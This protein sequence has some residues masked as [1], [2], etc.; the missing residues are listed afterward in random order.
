M[1]FKQTQLKSDTLPLHIREMLGEQPE[2][3]VDSL[4]IGE[5]LSDTQKKAFEKFK[6]GEDKR[7]KRCPFFMKCKI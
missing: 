6:K 3:D 2:F 4:K 7:C 5:N 1:S